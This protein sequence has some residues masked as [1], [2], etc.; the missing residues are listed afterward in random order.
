MPYA[1]PFLVLN[2]F[3][4]TTTVIPTGGCVARSPRGVVLLQ[5]MGRLQ[6][7]CLLRYA[8]HGGLLPHH[9][10]PARHHHRVQRRCGPLRVV[11]RHPPRNWQGEWAHK[12]GRDTCIH[13]YSMRV[14]PFS[15]RYILYD[16]KMVPQGSI[17]SNYFQVTHSIFI[18]LLSFL[19]YRWDFLS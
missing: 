11:R 9:R 6:L 14:K 4:T 12:R 10:A 13:K 19:L 18:S 17:K 15:H 7:G 1:L 16:H 3:T 5:T 8:E 2:L